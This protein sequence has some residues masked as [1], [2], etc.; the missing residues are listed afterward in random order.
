MALLERKRYKTR[1]HASW[2]EYDG[3]TVTLVV[4]RR[5]GGAE[6]NW[7]ELRFAGATVRKCEAAY[8]AYCAKGL[9]RIQAQA[10]R[11]ARWGP[12]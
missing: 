5:V 1:D 12:L 9:E 2:F 3:E 6:G 7:R 11:R 4:Q 8:D 10:R